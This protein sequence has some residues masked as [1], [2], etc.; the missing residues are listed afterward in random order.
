M[1]FSSFSKSSS[2]FF[3]KIICQTSSE[4][5]QEYFPW[6]FFLRVVSWNCWDPY[7]KENDH[8][9]DYW[10]LHFDI[11]GVYH[12]NL[13]ILSEFGLFGEIEGRCMC[14]N[15]LG[16]TLLGEAPDTLSNSE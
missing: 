12:E 15:T 6:W 13:E 11:W 4:P 1:T 9:G 3:A 8:R 16:Q 14:W 10:G 7:V 5:F 2:P